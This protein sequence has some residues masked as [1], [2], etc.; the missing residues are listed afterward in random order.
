MC[1]EIVDRAAAGDDL[2]FPIGGGGGGFLGAVAVEVGFEF[3]DAAQGAVFVEFR[4]G[5]EVGVPAAV[6]LLSYLELSRE[7]RRAYSG[8]QPVTSRSSPQ[9]R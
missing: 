3:D 6:Y 8:K 5:L 4:E 9:S 7:W 2:V 1:S